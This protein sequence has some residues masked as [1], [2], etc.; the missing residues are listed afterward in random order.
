MLAALSEKK[1]R[2]ISTIEDV[3]KRVGTDNEQDKRYWI[4]SPESLIEIVEHFQPGWE[5]VGKECPDTKVGNGFWL[6]FSTTKQP[7]LPTFEV[8]QPVAIII[9]TLD[10][11][12][13]EKTAKRALAAAGCDARVIIVSGSARGFTKT[14]NEGLKQTTDE[15]ICLLNDDIIKFPQNWLSDMLGG[16]YSDERNGI[17]GPSGKS[18]TAPASSGRP[19]MKG[20]RVCNQI[21]YW[22]VVLRR[23]MLDE[24]GY[25]DE[26]YIHYC[27]DNEYNIRAK[28]AGWRCVWLRS[29]YI[30]HEHHGSGI[31]K[32]WALHDQKVFGERPK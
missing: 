6:A 17:L 31:R 1:T 10:Q 9:P 29:V 13:G 4:F 16:L 3:L 19:G 30:D 7:V 18:G 21:S 15:D 8:K 24:I 28:K 20:M 27:S 11:A 2:T 32:E 26:R 23:E 25:L 22:C 14:V 12:K 5:L